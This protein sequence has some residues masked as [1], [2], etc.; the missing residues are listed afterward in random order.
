MYV[1]CGC[2]VYLLCVECGVCV[3]GVCVCVR[4]YV[5]CVQCLLVCML[6]VCVG[7]WDVYGRLV[8][9]VCGVEG[10]LSCE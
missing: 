7:V 9:Y 8:C 10:F 3:C 1:V 2:F 5:V 4:V 6:G